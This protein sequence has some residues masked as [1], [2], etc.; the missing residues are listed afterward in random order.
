MSL[1]G[2]LYVGQSGLQTSSNAL[3]TVAH[4]LSNLD[5]EGYTRQQV[6]ESTRIYN[7]LSKSA[8]AIS[9][10]E[11]GLGVRYAETRQVRDFFLDKT[12]RT[13]VGRLNFYEV[14]SDVLI[15]LEDIL[16]EGNEEE[17]F[18]GAL[19]DLWTTIQELANEPNSSVT[20]GLFVSKAQTL[21]ERAKS[22]YSQISEYQDNLNSRV[23]TYV[24]Q[25]N[26]YGKRLTELN[27][28]IAKIES[29][30]VENAN[31]LRDERNLILDKLS[32]LCKITYAEDTDGFVNVKIEGE[33][34]V[35]R[36]SVYEIGL[37]QEKGTGFY[38]PYWK[39]N[40]TLDDEGNLD[41][42]HAKVFNFD[43]E[44]SSDLDTDIG[45]LKSIIL[46]RGEKRGVASDLSDATVY[47]DD[48]AESACVNIEAEFDQLIVSIVKQINQILSDAGYCTE[49]GNG[50][51]FVTSDGTDDWYTGNISVNTVYL[52]TP[53]LLSFMKE[54][55]TVDYDT[56]TAL[57]DLF[58]TENLTLNP[59]LTRKTSVLDYY[60]D[61]VE[62]VT[63]SSS[64]AQ[65]VYSAQETTVE[66]AANAR[67]EVLGVSSD[68]ELQFMIMY[69]N[70]F[71]AS[72]RYITTVN[73]MLESIINSFGV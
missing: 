68:E 59:N 39:L 9:Y 19:T 61:L 65:A 50:T 53:A 5:T 72:S 11:V 52:Q 63:N 71:N 55:E 4:N 20:Q 67:T 60:S 46:A 64:V 51:L 41:I 25:I 66:S 23:S 21:I 8:S 28:E 3:N 29:N 73:D 27:L 47:N 13:E 37:Y 58:E 7:I 49:E 62:Q 42:S 15:Q 45:K 34:F 35:K 1:F 24:D 6:S 14:S 17:A 36:D 12:Y 22:V 69:Q 38:T 57:K 44:V 2:A 43:I 40:A 54:D 56:A 70:A 16:N 30:G 32:E 31:D 33:D 10:Q 26:D 48:I 18:S